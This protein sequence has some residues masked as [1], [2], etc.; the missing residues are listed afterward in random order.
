M[1]KIIS[2]FNTLFYIYKSTYS[3]VGAWTL[4][5]FFRMTVKDIFHRRGIQ[6]ER[7]CLMRAKRANTGTDEYL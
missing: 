3:T 7:D 6:S 5:T 1:H 2:V 4:N